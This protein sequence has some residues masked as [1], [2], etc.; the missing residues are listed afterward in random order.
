[1][2]KLKMITHPDPLA[3]GIMDFYFNTITIG[4]NKKNNLIFKSEQIA[5]VHLILDTFF[6]NNEHHASLETVNEELFFFV[7]DKKFFGKK[8]LKINDIVKI[9][10]FSFQILGYEYDTSNNWSKVFEEQ[11]LKLYQ[12]PAERDLLKIIEKNLEEIK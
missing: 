7:N 3:I 2:I 11:Y 10:Q 9:D 8:I 4:K 1:M 6:I 12:D 5:P